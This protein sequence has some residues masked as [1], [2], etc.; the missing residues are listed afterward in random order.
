MG[1]VCRRTI[2]VAR[3]I[4][5]ILGTHPPPR[6]FDLSWSAG[7]DRVEGVVPFRGR[8]DP[9]SLIF[10]MCLLD[11]QFGRVEFLHVVQALYL[12]QVPIFPQVCRSHLLAHTIRL[13]Q[14]QYIP[15]SLDLS[16]GTLTARAHCQAD[17][18]GQCRYASCEET[19]SVH[20]RSIL[21][22]RG[23][24]YTLQFWNMEGKSGTLLLPARR[25]KAYLTGKW[26]VKVVPS[27][28]RLATVICPP[29]SSIRSLQRARPNPA[30]RCLP[31]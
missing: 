9:A 28:R 10:Q 15:A 5:K 22:I 6:I 29:F 17:R 19:R 24:G 30:H 11:Q 3:R 7:K 26:S 8:L 27:A 18:N 1:L 31:S 13:D 20:I 21:G 23:K 16:L 12:N 14:F 25:L 4:V 2:C